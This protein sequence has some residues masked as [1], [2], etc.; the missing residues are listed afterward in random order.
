MVK[1]LDEVLGDFEQTEEE[2]WGPRKPIT[3][4]IPES[5]K[6]KYDKIQDKSSRRFCKKL[7]ELVL[8]AIDKTD[9][10]AS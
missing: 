4:W 2:T 7:R 9:L 6:I 8:I 10:K 5:Y 3:I 1:S